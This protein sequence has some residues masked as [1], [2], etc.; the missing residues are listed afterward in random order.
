MHYSLVGFAP[1][2]WFQFIKQ[3]VV[4]S[5][6]VVPFTPFTPPF[7]SSWHNASSTMLQTNN[8]NRKFRL[9]GKRRNCQLEYKFI[10]FC[11]MTKMRKIDLR[12][13]H[14]ILTQWYEGVKDIRVCPLGTLT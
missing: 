4:T 5:L 1:R 9:T 14:L 3:N 7:S 11:L 2:L 13:A 10:Y 8:K 12:A 6:V